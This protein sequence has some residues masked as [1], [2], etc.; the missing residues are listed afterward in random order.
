MEIKLDWK[1]IS[2]T[3]IENAKAR[4]NVLLKNYDSLKR[5]LVGAVHQQSISV[6]SIMLRKMFAQSA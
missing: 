5:C 1:T 3:T 2:L 4:V 6:Q